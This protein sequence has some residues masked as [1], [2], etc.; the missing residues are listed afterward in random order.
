MSTFVQRYT[1]F[2][3]SEPQTKQ[4]NILYSM[5][6]NEKQCKLKI[7]NNVWFLSQNQL[8]LLFKTE[9]K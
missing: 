8:F 9:R 5:A 3:V 4:D 6:V 2:M 7:F 1:L